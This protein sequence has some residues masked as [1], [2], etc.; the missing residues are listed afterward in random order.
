MRADGR[1]AAGLAALALASCSSSSPP[2]AAV[3]VGGSR[4][5]PI[6]VD[7][8]GRSLYVFGRDTAGRS[9]CTEA[10]ARVWPPAT[11]TAR[12]RGG[13][14][15]AAAKLGVIRRADHRLQLTYG[16]HPLY[17]FSGDT[18]RREIGGEGFLGT[19]FLVSPAGRP[20]VDPRAARAPAGY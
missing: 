12:P 14:G 10:C 8:A 20:V 11:V 17:R 1:V 7:Q 16:G 19:W 18:A 13:P 15:V 6:L 5:G 9:A 3:G 2:P 4:L